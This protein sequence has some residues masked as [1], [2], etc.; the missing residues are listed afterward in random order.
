R[1]F[2][3][4]ASDLGLK[5][6]DDAVRKQI[7]DMAAQLTSNGQSKEQMVRQILRTQ[8]IS[9]SEFVAAIRQ[10]TANNLLRAGLTAPS[11]LSS[12]LLAENLYR[13]DN[14]KRAADII[15][16]TN[17]GV[18]GIEEPTEEN[19]RKYYDANKMDYL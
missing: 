13:Y 14:E 10:E 17:A 8:G 9:E 18:E 5:V 6:G 12:P 2:S 11:T 1:L 16:L 15:V 4:A 3:Q 19:L 7:A